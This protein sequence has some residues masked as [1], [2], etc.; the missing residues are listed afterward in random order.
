M[1]SS[2]L[3]FDWDVDADL[4]ADFDLDVV[5]E[6]EGLA[7][8]LARVCC[9]FFVVVFFGFLEVA[10]GSGAVFR[11]IEVEVSDEVGCDSTGVGSFTGAGDS[12][13]AGVLEMDEEVSAPSR[14]GPGSNG[15][16]LGVAF[17]GPGVGVTDADNDPLF[18][19]TAPAP[20]NCCKLVCF[21]ENSSQNF[22]HN[23]GG[24]AGFPTSLAFAPSTSLRKI[25]SPEG[26]VMEEWK[27][28]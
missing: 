18:C 25:V 1:S 24:S 13:P 8:K 16:G 28:M 26:V 15:T 19:L 4:E 27:S 22:A 11:F 2:P 21:P 23:L 12:L 14:A 20:K 3:T 9:P 10:L 6:V 5:E 17:L 7:K